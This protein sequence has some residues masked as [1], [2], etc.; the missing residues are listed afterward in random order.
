MTKSEGLGRTDSGRN[1]PPARRSLGILY[2]TGS[3]PGFTQGGT[4]G[5]GGTLPVKPTPKPAPKPAP[6]PVT[7]TG[8]NPPTH[9]TGATTYVK[10]RAVIPIIVSPKTSTSTTTDNAELSAA[11]SQLASNPCGLTEAQFSLLQQNGQIASTLPFSSACQIAATGTTNPTASN[12][13][14]LNDPE[15]LAQGLF[16]GP[17]PNCS[18]SDPLCAAQG[19]TGGPYPN[20]TAASSSNSLLPAN[21]NLSD[22]TTWPWYL[23]AVL[24]GGGYLLFHSKKKSRRR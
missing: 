24:L 9:T 3:R 6:K 8:T 21:F 18:T 1:F 16:G 17:Y 15:C 23:W 10:P 4:P 13:S 20:C 14:S 12:E 7:T 2:V 11:I 22:V 19:M 5:G